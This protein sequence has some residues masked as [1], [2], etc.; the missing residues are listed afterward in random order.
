MTVDDSLARLRAGLDRQERQSLELCPG[1]EPSNAKWRVDSIALTALGD[2][3]MADFVADHSPADVLRMVEA[4]RR[5]IVDRDCAASLLEPYVKA[6]VD[7]RAQ[8]A[9]VRALDDVIEAL[10][11]IYPDPTEEA[12]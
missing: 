11:S 12:S 1:R 10:A 9:V 2:R 7:T 8:R 5:V 6:G 3:K 4:I